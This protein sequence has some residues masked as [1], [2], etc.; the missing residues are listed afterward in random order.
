MNRTGE[1]NKYVN[2]HVNEEQKNDE[3]N[4]KGNTYVRN[5]III[6]E[7]G[8]GDTSAQGHPVE[9]TICNVRTKEYALGHRTVEMPMRG[10]IDKTNLNKKNKGL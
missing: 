6:P 9:V 10:E 4:S 7:N 2:K 3:R 1:L 8:N 5:Q